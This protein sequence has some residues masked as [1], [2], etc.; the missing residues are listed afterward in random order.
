M[1]LDRW[2]LPARTAL[3]ALLAFVL[4]L[5]LGGSGITT[6]PAAERDR[7]R[8]SAHRAAAKPAQRWGTATGG[9][10]TG[11]NANRIIPASERARYP[12]HTTRAAPA[13]PPNRASVTSGPAGA[14]AGF[15]RRTSRVRTPRDATER[16]YD[17]ADGTQTT[18]FS[19]GPPVEPGAGT[20]GMYVR[21]GS[22]VKG[23]SELLV[24]NDG[25]NAAAYVRFDSVSSRLAGHT[26]LGAG[27]SL[28]NFD[29]GSCRSRP[30]TVHPVTQSWSDEGAYSYPGPSVGGSL[31]SAS[32]AHGHIPLGSAT[33]PCPMAAEFVDLGNGGRQVV[34]RW[35]DGQPNHGLSLRATTSD[36]KD[37]KKF[38]G[39]GTANRPTLYVTH[40][41]YNAKYEIPNPVPNPPVTQIQDGKVK[42]TVTNTGSE[43]WTPSTYYLAYRA[44]NART[45]VSVVQQ[46]AATLP[47]TV[48]RNAKVTL[49]ATI[50]ALPPG[51]YFLD[52]T[53]VRTG[54]AVFTDFQVPPA[55]I[56]LHVI[57]IP[58]VVAELY[59]PNGYQA[60]TL[61]PLLWARAVDTDAP[62]G[63]TLQFRFEVCDV[64]ADNK[65]V[66]CTNS[67][68]Q[69]RQAWT[70]PAG[71]LLWGR[72]YQWRTTVKDN[73]NETVSAY[74]TIIASVPQPDVVSR[75]AGAPYAETGREFDANTGN[76][77]TAALDAV[78][79]TAGP[80]LNV[81]RTYNSMDPRVDGAFGAGW[82]SR[83][84]MKVVPDGDG[85]GNVVVTYQDGQAVRFGRNPDGSYAPPAGRTAR[86]TTTGTQ[87]VLLDKSGTT[88]Y[89]T[90]GSGKL[91]K[92]TDN[93]LRSVILSPDGAGRPATVQV[94]N[95]Q[96]NRLGRKLTFV[97][98]GNHVR[99]VRTDKVGGAELTWQYFYTGDLLTKVC[100]PEEKCTQYEYSAGS[101]YRTAVQDAR[102]ESYWRL[103]DTAP[104]AGA[105]S[106][107]GAASDVGV[108]LGQDA[109]TYQNVTLGAAGA[110]AGTTDTAASF[111]GTNSSVTLPRGTLKKSRDAAVEVWFKV[112]LTQTGGPL[113]GYQ[114]K[115]LGTASTTGVPILYTGTDGLLR[116]QFAV[117]SINPITSAAV[118]N[119]NV[120]HHAVLTLI[121][122]TQTL[123]LDGVRAGE[124]TGVTV[125][126]T[127]LSENQ[128]G[129][130]YAT[131]TWPGW[132]GTAQRSFHGVI[133]EVAVYHHPLGE[134][135]VKAH[136]AMAS[137]AAQQLSKVIRPSGKVASE[138]TYDT[139]TDRVKEY[140]DGNGGTWDVGRP[141]VYGDDHDL[142]RSI[143][144]NDPADRPHLYEYDA[145]TGRMLR[146]GVP[147]G[148][149][150][151]AE[152]QPR[153]STP[154]ADP[155]A[156]QCTRPDPQDPGF[157][158]IIPADSGGPVFVRHPLEGMA[159]RS[160]SYN[161]QG[162]Q[163]QV[164]NENG[165]S[166]DLTYDKRGNVLTRTTCRTE[167]QCSTAYTTYSATVTDEFDPR[168]DLAVETRDARSASAADPKYVTRYAYA[169]VTGNL[170][171]QTNPDGSRV[172]HTY[173]T[174]A[175]AAF[176][177]GNPPPGLLASTTDGR[178]KVTRFRYLQN[179]DLAQVTDPKGLI[180]EY[181]YDPIGR[182]IAE[183]QISD[184]FPDGV[185]TAYRYDGHGRMTTSI[186]PATTDA[187]SGVR[188]QTQITTTYD[189]DGNVTGATAA[190]LLGGDPPRTSLTEYD[191]FNRP[192]RQVDPLGHETTAGYDRFGNKVTEQ[193]P[194]GNR[195]DY[196]YTAQN[197]IAE[198]RARDWRGDPEGAPPTG[199]GDH[200]VLHRYSY[201][202]AGRLASDTDAM[203][204]RLEYQYY[205]DD[206]LQRVVM[207]NF[208]DPDGSTR[209][210]VTEETEYD[211][212]GHPV[213]KILNNRTQVVTNEVDAAGKVISTTAG[214]GPEQRVTTFRYDGNGNV[215]LT[216]RTG[217]P[218]NLPWPVAAQT[219]QV[220]YAYDDGNQMIRQTVTAGDQTQVTVNDYDDRGVP[221]SATDPRG[222]VT[223]ADPAAYTTTFVNDE[224]GRTT[225]VRGAPVAAES[226]GQPAATVRPVSK[227]G[228]NAFGE[229][230]ASLDPLGN[231]SRSEY[232][233]LGRVVR[234]IA[235]SYTA[236]GASEAV[237]PVTENRYDAN[238]NV[239]ESVDADGTST[240]FTFDQLDRLTV[241]D[242]PARTNDERAITRYAYTRTG[243]TL[244][245]TG[246]T[247]ARVETTYDDLD[248]A[249]SSTQVERYPVTENF[250]SRL[251][252]DD[253]ANVVAMRSASGALTSNAFDGQ[254]QVTR[255]TSPTGVVTE[256]GYDYAGRQVRVTD[257]KGR[258]TRVGYDLFGRRISD[259]SLN[260]AGTTLRSTT[261][262]YDPAG[263]L[264]ASTDPYSTRTTY[265]YDAANQLVRQVEPVSATRSITTSWGYD[266]A[267]NRT[268][269]T[270]GRGHATV[271]TVNSLGLS[272]ST[273]EPATASHP[274]EADR[275][276]SVGYDKT[277]QPV[278]LTAPGGV[279]RTRGYDAAGRLTSETGA[280]AEAAT[281]ARSLGYDIAGRL[282]TVGAPGGEDRYTYDDRDNLL[283]VT[284]P[285]GAASFVVD[286]DSQ[287]TSRTDA[288][289]TAT[290]TYDRGRLDTVKDALT[291]V[292][293]KLGYD[294]AGMLST[295]EYG[296]L[297]TRTYG[298]DDFGHVA[299]DTIRNQSG[300]SVS[301]ITYGFD[302]NGQIKSKNTTGTAGAGQNTYDYDKAGRLI[303]WT[304]AAGTV[305]YDWDDSGNRTRAGPKTSTFDERNRLLADGDYTYAYTARGTL[306]TRTSSG[307]AEPYTSD[308]FDRMTTAPGVTYTYD[309]ADR[310]ATRNGVRWAYGGGGDDPVSD[311]A[312]KF[313]R[314]P[315][316]ELLAVGQGQ[317]AR[318]TI[319]DVHGDIVAVLD[320]TRPT[321]AKPASSTAYDPWGKVLA[322]DGDTGNLGFQGDYTDPAT[323]QV[324][325]GAR[326]YNPGSGTFGSRDSLG[327]STG[328]S[329]LAN[330]YTYGAGAPLDHDDP[331]GHLPRWV[332]SGWN[333]VKSVTSAG[334]KAVTTGWG[335][336]KQGVGKVFSAFRASPLGRLTS[337]LYH[338]SGA[339]RVVAKVK[340]GFD[341]AA[342]G[343]FK[344]WSKQ[345]YHA[346][347]KE[348]AKK[349]QE[350]TRRAMAAVRTAIKY[351]P[352]PVLAA[353]AKPL[354]KVGGK[355]I[356]SAVTIAPA[357][358]ALTVQAIVDPSKFAAVVYHKAVERYGAVVE[359]VSKAADA[360]GQFVQEHQDA[361][362]EGLAIVG[363]IAA[364]AACTVATAGAGAVACVAG[365]AALINLAKD[366]A[367][368]D[369]DSLGDAV[370]SAGI[371]GAQGL[372]GGGSGLVGSKVA[373]AV[374]G[375]L[376]GLGGH[377]ISGGV[378]GAVSDGV[379]QY[380]AT[381]RVNFAGVATSAGIGAVT[382]GFGRGG[383]GCRNSF[384][385][386]TGVLTPDGGTRRI[387]LVR[388]GDPVV[389]TD[390]TTGRTENRV[391]TDVITGTG[392][393]HLVDITVDTGD[394]PHV[395]TA[396]DEHPFWVTDLR[397]WV[398][399]TN[400]RPGYR[401]ET[402][403]HRQATVH[404]TRP[405]TEW[406]TVY[407]L[408]VDGLH[409]FYVAAGDAAVLVHNDS[410]SIAGQGGVGR[411]TAPGKANHILT[412]DL[413][414]SAG[415]S[416]VSG[417]LW[418]GN[419]TAAER[420]VDGGWNQQALTH[421]ENRATRMFGLPSRF[422][423]VGDT[424]FGV[425][426]H[427][428][429]EDGD[430][431]HLTGTRPPCSR[432]KGSMTE[433]AESSGADITYHGPTGRWP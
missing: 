264:V 306:R 203:G 395:I 268:R 277:L 339:D 79:G 297:S 316:G 368:G 321:P 22:T 331:D 153:P 164:V 328:D 56:V 113:V 421:T 124:Q 173:T 169:P 108:N 403:D 129:A 73:N 28:V 181:T 388:V 8:A 187:V 273:V 229:A 209:D 411:W 103:G 49:D 335:Y 13:A 180:T 19:A 93:A 89:F 337:Y 33:S 132:G 381:G 267:G 247:G 115:A 243:E 310:V 194:N 296:A 349:R 311:G 5:D 54:G 119:N 69:A 32:F 242:E 238:G 212:A 77:S 204:R 51:V 433:F 68:F 406:T 283:G 172:K 1:Q 343:Q 236:P 90:L 30:I 18:E 111:G 299:S 186:G 240:R 234:S 417:S 407:N 167:N 195:T 282:V 52:Y 141:A 309:G 317:Q 2:R 136:R 387:S 248:R 48:A 359:T 399:P 147:L 367:Q 59:P 383:S 208:H 420:S 179:G 371:G 12:L 366:A 315:G 92:I 121:G 106:N 71:R 188:H 302:L 16:V 378:D 432:C 160:F 412:Y 120:W 62:P 423:V 217:S 274:A 237:V 87:W 128:I 356:Q 41:P 104:G 363:S 185:T 374:G 3:A 329:I 233:R 184:T 370:K 408:T 107:S 231:V 23:G 271:Y 288:A 66:S 418:S 305:G 206:L 155:P 327:Y 239:I 364:G 385:G 133:D 375:R 336:A 380:A 275:T 350:V 384:T 312:E 146:S 21:G 47:G 196:A 36:S 279:S 353:A 347:R 244:S 202:F 397:T 114:N 222:T 389:A 413:R 210:Y 100:S 190:D 63:Q 284:G 31:A 226:N 427:I 326:W 39:T 72:N 379:A 322:T 394:G 294:N 223:G 338:K 38:G 98:E 259:S 372:L 162:Y 95:S 391:V 250:T 199:T 430:T 354:I 137:P 324:D 57:D 27:L 25:Q 150:T 205:R 152:D 156:E 118:V 351:S 290:F 346:A 9:S 230:V 262:E 171:E 361:I 402:A 82:S 245:V 285:S 105:V 213:K 425:F 377:L 330:R 161:A 78:V 20:G 97:W 258:T 382:S 278:R 314:G 252:Y 60:P 126:A 270:D 340:E 37:W 341:A 419:M 332:K 145:I 263:N 112:G 91:A 35:A 61:Q 211:G 183:K 197:K 86:L 235:P 44:Y 117:G 414:S 219:E 182:K 174:G 163:S 304:S 7:A 313:A 214:P 215:V 257:G 355:L 392:E 176:D 404:S 300:Q 109:G 260:A 323:Q 96:T 400:L 261:Y 360:V 142:R 308:A 291:G 123:Y 166:V 251:T 84:D 198:I 81:A 46:R 116:G 303:A 280:G 55:R 318:L 191:E 281:A 345:Q 149:E 99:Q 4:A 334:W 424:Y 225:E 14:K 373:G 65:P 227:V 122:T 17:N 157:C 75:V 131:G 298:Y 344:E 64:D 6:V 362:I 276:W 220:A 266:A 127:L 254:G 168:R 175:E 393:K 159:I 178:D 151:R 319:G 143:Q 148:L 74:S 358:L 154:P 232:D 101:H 15:D 207:K 165:Y 428:P 287:V 272:E 398:L 390:P 85:S 67:G 34:Q 193:D 43:A 255:T 130:A 177:S 376:S 286:A 125:D 80:D 292:T 221:I 224:L 26:I 415:H 58:A 348:L 45:G 241:L 110:L 401:F 333:K 135:T 256:F 295:V 83:Y 422:E 357:V 138:I 40:S 24:G 265:A 369:I 200:L 201:D 325:M 431:L 365:S 88:Y 144:V 249:V 140:T 396:T 253:A 76:L 189:A 289:G 426:N 416:K 228:Y 269:Y 246:P 158:T 70:V 11:R 50:K 320:P 10:V 218:S 405:R 410:C 29:A 409:T 170:T 429:I 192:V 139:A 53:M 352:L 134:A 216:T 307:L 42:V 293:Q 342:T 102:P 94:S 301:S 386:D